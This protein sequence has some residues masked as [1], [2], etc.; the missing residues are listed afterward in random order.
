MI[1][2][3]VR[4]H[5]FAGIKDKSYTFGKELTIICGPN[6]EGKSTAARAVK[7]V[8][9]LDTNL[10]PAKKQTALRDLLPVAGGDTIRITLEFLFENDSYTLSKSWGGTSAVELKSSN[11]I[12]LTNSTAVQQRIQEMLPANQAVVEQVLVASQSQLA[13]AVDK[14]S[15]NVQ[16][17]LSDQLRTTVLKGGGIS[18]TQLEETVNSRA[19]E[20]FGRWDEAA[21][22]IEGGAGRGLMN[23]WKNRVGHIAGSWYKLQEAIELEKQ[24]ITYDTELN[25][26]QTEL[27]KVNDE[28]TTFTGYLAQHKAAYDSVNNRISIE[29]AR[30]KF[31]SALDDFAKDAYRWP[32]AQA[33]LNSAKD[34]F[35]AIQQELDEVKKEVGYA[36]QKQHA[37]DDTEKLARINELVKKAEDAERSAINQA[38]ISEADLTQAK[39]YQQELNRCQSLIDGQKLRMNIAPAVAGTIEIIHS[40]AQNE[41]VALT[42]GQDVERNISGKVSF[43][44]QG[45]SFT[46]QSANEDIETLENSLSKTSDVL[47]L[48]LRKYNQP[49][50]EALAVAAD[51]Y[52]STLT[53]IKQAKSNVQAALG[54]D[55]LESLEY[56]CKAAAALPGTRDV[57]V[58]DELMHSKSRVYGQHQNNV[59]NLQ[60]EISEFEAKHVSLQNLDERRLKG[61][62]AVAEKEKE[63]D[64]LAPLPTGYESAAIFQKKY[65]HA[66]EKQRT[67]GE[68]KHS[69][70]LQKQ[71][72]QEPTVS[73]SDAKEQTQRARAAF[74]QALQEGKAF[75]RIQ[76]SLQTLLASAD[77]NAFMPLH[78]KTE[79]YLARL[80]G[81]RFNRIPFDATEPQR[82][83]GDNVSL[84]VSL[85]SKGTKDILALSLRLAAADVYLES[86]AGFV[87]MD[88]PLVDMDS[89]RRKAA[90]E[91]LSEFAARHQ[92]ILFTCHDL[93]AGLFSDSAASE[94]ALTAGRN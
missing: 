66:L 15:E 53:A 64:A 49:S 67:A 21:G 77:E 10:T 5:P 70:E 47:H 43:V 92:T 14:L 38:E 57:N 51:Q 82:L 36:R 52:K 73:L 37:K 25:R 30:D 12:T 7:Q 65:A 46:I 63:L 19:E 94:N 60:K 23:P 72:L 84:P 71:A 40:G 11:G 55:T 91:V 68:Q 31:K 32:V 29:A 75:R 41:T 74:D 27:N 20:Y 45:V 69:L 48:I 81:G 35:L 4:L 28:L 3:S 17:S 78:Q 89:A 9:F 61:M 80:S 88:D 8:L 58:L 62:Q 90:A 87:M 22:T 18:A 33:E 1:L 34:A 93:H 6:E 42:P 59:A 50:V 2:Q 44:W 26:L 13:D 83:E 79:T 85:L 86:K 24:I 56:R 76:S 54:N 39:K 16:S